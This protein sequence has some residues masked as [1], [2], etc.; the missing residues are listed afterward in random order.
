HLK[1]EALVRLVVR[2]GKRVAYVEQL[3]PIGHAGPYC[4]GLLARV[5]PCCRARC[6]FMVAVAITHNL[7]SIES[8]I[9][10]ALSLL[11]LEDLVR[12]RLVAVKPNE[13]WASAE[14]ISGVTQGVT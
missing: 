4:I 3:G 10:Q 13:T 6:R 12:S 11:P 14:D 5:V 9:Q 2:G 8:A 1:A 7:K